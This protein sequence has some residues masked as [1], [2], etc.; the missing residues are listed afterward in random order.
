MGTHN[1][2]SIPVPDRNTV[3][4]TL[5]TSYT[6][7]KMIYPQRLLG[8]LCI[9]C[10]LANAM[11]RT[12]FKAGRIRFADGSI[13]TGDGYE[14]K[15]RNGE[16]PGSPDGWGIYTGN[17]KVKFHNGKDW[18]SSARPDWWGNKTTKYGDEKEGE[19][20]DGIFLHGYVFLFRLGDGIYR[21]GLR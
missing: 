21:G 6:L 7:I 8:A 4:H 1:T 5:S 11:E 14:V 18:K 12:I 13:Y 2:F 10:S 19:W 20:K 16:V 17:G 15:F 3:F 9:L